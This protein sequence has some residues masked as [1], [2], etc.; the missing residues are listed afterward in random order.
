MSPDDNM[1][2]LPWESN[3]ALTFVLNTLG[4]L[5]RDWRCLELGCG[6][7]VASAVA[8]AHGASVCATD[9]VAEAVAGARQRG[10]DARV[11]RWED[12]A[13]VEQYELVMGSDLFFAERCAI[14]IAALL[15]RVGCRVALFSSPP[16]QPLLLFTELLRQHYACVVCERVEL[17]DCE[18]CLVAL[19][20][21]DS[22]SPLFACV[23]ELIA[24]HKRAPHVIICDTA[25][26]PPPLPPV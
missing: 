8:H 18:P 5:L 13:F 21:D 17:P 1:W 7:S 22:E 10:I 25:P 19:A 14:D 9:A 26:L 23:T 12:T 20:T 3:E 15:Q 6:V 24:A 11:L 16:R 4:I 2:T